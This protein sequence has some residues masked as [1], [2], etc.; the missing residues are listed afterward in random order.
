MVGGWV[1]LLAWCSMPAHRQRHLATPTTPTQAVSDL[2][3]DCLS[4]EPSE[5]PTAQQ[6]M[7][8]LAAIEP[9]ARAIMEERQGGPTPVRSSA[10]EPLSA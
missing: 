3:V 9:S 6:L 10:P 5:R 4:H 8:H 7:R 1:R 2:M